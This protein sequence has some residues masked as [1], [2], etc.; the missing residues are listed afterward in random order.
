[1]RLFP[2]LLALLFL[3][4]CFLFRKSDPIEWDI[5]AEPESE[6]IK[7]PPYRAAA[8]LHW[9]LVHTRLNLKLDI[10]GQALEGSAELEI[11]PH[12][13]TQDSLVLDAKR[14]QVSAVQWKTQSGEWTQP[15]AWYQNSDTTQL[16]IRPGK[17]L[18]AGD[19]PV[20]Q[21][22]YRTLPKVDEETG[23]AITQDKGIYFIDPK[24]EDPDVPFQLWTQGE[25]ES[26]SQWF[27]T[28]DKP[29]QKTTQEI[30]FTVPDSLI[31]LSNGDLSYSTRQ[32]ANGTR[33]DVWIQEKPHAPYLAMLAA[34]SWTRID[35][36]KEGEL[37]VQYYVEKEYAPYAKLVFGQTPE[38]IRFF[39]QITGVAYPWDKYAQI[40]VRDFVSGAMENTGAV[41]H[42]T[43]MHHNAREHADNTQED[44]ISHELFHHWF[45]NYVTCESWS[46][47]TL[48][49]GFATYGE[50]LWREHR[51]GLDNAEEHRLDDLNS[52]IGNTFIPEMRRPVIDFHYQEADNMFDAHSYQKGGLIL[53]AL[54][55]YL[56]D[57][58]FFRGM[59]AY[60]KNHAYGT[61]EIHDLRRVYEEV[62]G[63]DLNW[64]FD[65]WLFQAGHPEL[66]Y[67]GQWMP[68]E[69]E[70]GLQLNFDVFWQGGPGEESNTYRLP[71]EIV[72]SVN[73]SLQRRMHWLT[74]DVTTHT[75][76]L[77]MEQRP[78]WIEV[79]GQGSFIGQVFND[80]V[81]LEN[82]GKSILRK[83]QQAPLSLW[84]VNA[85]DELYERFSDIT[86]SVLVTDILLTA[87]KDKSAWVRKEALH[88][89]FSRYLLSQSQ[90]QRMRVAVEKVAFSDADVHVREKAVYWLSSLDDSALDVQFTALTMDSSISVAE[91]A[92]GAIRNNALAFTRAAVGVS[93]PEPAIATAWLGQL[94]DRHEE[95][96][97]AAALRP[98]INNNAIGRSERIQK[99][100]S[101][102]AELKPADAVRWLGILEPWLASPSLRDYHKVIGNA[103]KQSLSDLRAMAEYMEEDD[104]DEAEKKEFDKL[105][106]E[107]DRL[108]TVYSAGH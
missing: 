41:V 47:L 76:F 57:A 45:G 33:T 92:M 51:Y 13:R 18:Q 15:A 27:P 108:A 102:L 8:P 21:I 10:P 17:A 79:D 64:F 98:Y 16:I 32:P 100:C 53:H 67:G 80:G 34:G 42:N 85:L 96:D 44:Y 43:V 11:T 87:M 14:M 71:L 97:L 56:G 66:H 84:K 95:Q 90:K 106:S 49:E 9:K 72:T 83:V 63:E 26:S 6:T 69:G 77:E 3:P 52:Y 25:T 73:G 86:D 46:N 89:I 103:L 29:N 36:H 7:L 82:E 54:R 20:F 91:A 93:D 60:L 107:V 22:R 28:L 68:V 30:A 70:R 4:G 55:K 31:T 40:V 35:D 81:G 61:V 99:A 50:Y 48:N 78:D 5:P 88:S 65:Q 104:M 19:T 58:V 59:Q 105:M 24:N 75:L 101:W 38:M 62:A 1:M 94:L 37:P 23:F 74:N 12:A 39:N 2:L